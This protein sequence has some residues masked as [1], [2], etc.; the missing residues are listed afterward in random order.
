MLG[1]YNRPCHFELQTN[2][3]IEFSLSWN[4]INARP[5]GEFGADLY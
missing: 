1:D 5:Q 4:R 3:R 2:L